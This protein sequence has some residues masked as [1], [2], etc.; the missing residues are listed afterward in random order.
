[1]T[2]EEAER[3]T[4]VEK[5]LLNELPLVTRDDFEAHFFECADCAANLR[6][7]SAFMEAAKRELQHPAVSPQ[8]GRRPWR[9]WL[10]PSWS[11]PALSGLCAALFAVVISQNMSLY[12][13]APQNAALT[14][15][16]IMPSL[17]LVGGDSRGGAVPLITVS[18]GDSF[19]LSL[20]VPT[21]DKFIAY[22]CELRSAANTVAWR[23]GI[24]AAQASDTLT[25]RVPTSGL[26]S[27]DYSLV[28]HGSSAAAS[29][30]VDLARY[31]FRLSVR[32]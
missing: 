14:A 1:M 6:A 2:H 27:G 5:Y 29:T 15:P 17:S 26:D 4:A 21:N 3:L 19:A 10:A 25:I 30:P 11:V 22:D 31:R 23:L 9:E 28:V 8:R 13:R 24:G 18:Q 20:D 7:T 12:P 16:Q 32:H